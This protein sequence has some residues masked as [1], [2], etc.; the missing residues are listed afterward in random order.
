MLARAVAG[1]SGVPFFYASGSDFEELYW[2]VGAQRVRAL[3]ATAKERSPAIIFIDEL[4]AIGGKRE[5]GA[6]RHV[7][8]V[9]CPP[10]S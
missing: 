3:F 5:E 1:E 2:G 8:A 9:C 4:D 6:V 10:R 7:L